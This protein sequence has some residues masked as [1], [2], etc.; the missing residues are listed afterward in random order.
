MRVF[1]AG[2]TGVLGRRLVSTLSGR[3]HEVVGLSRGP[4]ND[5]AIRSSGGEVRR[6]D[7]FD[8][9]SLSSAAEG[10]DVVV[11]TATSIPSGVRFRRDDWIPNDRI[12]TEG[13]RALLDACA[14]V[15]AKAYVQEG[16]VW[17]ATPPDGS[18]FDEGAAEVPRLWFRSARESERIAQ[19]AADKHGFSAATVRFGSFYSADSG[20]TRYMGER[21]ARGKLPIIGRGNNFWSCTHVDDAADAMGAVV[22]AGASGIWHA[23]DSEPVSLGMFFGALAEAMNAP[24]PGHVPRWLARLVLGRYTLEFMTLSTRTSAA[25]LHRQLGWSPRYPTVREGFRQIVDQWRTDGLLDTWG[26]RA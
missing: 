13:T 2:A 16:I 26:A 6:A 20:Q 12:R 3:G 23:V 19:E 17:I 9:D 24:S 5:A 10:S 18:P 22:E 1:V 15:R 8:A 25:K 4:E 14:R 7:L 21:I 11:R